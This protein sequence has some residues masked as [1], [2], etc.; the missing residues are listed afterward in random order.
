MA[1]LDIERQKELEPKRM[2]YAK[3]QIQK[4]GYEISFENDTE[5]RFEFNGNTVKLFPYSGWHT[6]KGV[7]S[8]RG[9]NKLLKQIRQ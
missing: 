9:L 6:G 7:I 2:A 3:E 1:R 8:G 4:L 5:I